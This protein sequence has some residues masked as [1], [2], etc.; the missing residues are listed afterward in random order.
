MYSDFCA[1]QLYRECLGLYLTAQIARSAGY[2]GIGQ[3]NRLNS[4]RGIPVGMHRVRSSAL[5]SGDTYGALS[6][7]MYVVV[8]ET[9]AEVRCTG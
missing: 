2:L 4:H 3:F 6:P 1:Y 9:K 8:G 7:I 5:K